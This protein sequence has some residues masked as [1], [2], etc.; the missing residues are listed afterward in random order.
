MCA[1]K[2]DKVNLEGMSVEELEVLKERIDAQIDEVQSE[3]REKFIEMMKAEAKKMGVPIED[4]INTNPRAK[5]GKASDKRA[6]VK[7][8]YRDKNGNEWTGRGRAPKWIL[9]Y[10][11]TEKLDKNDP[12]QN[13][14][15]EKLFIK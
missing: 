14:K 3:K 6:Q 4:I 11:G 2:V 8:K 5:V 13:R 9:E 7:P 10:V 15:L 1:D 12:Q